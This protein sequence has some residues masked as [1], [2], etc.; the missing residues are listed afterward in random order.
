MAERKL[1]TIDVRPGAVM[2]SQSGL[3][4]LHPR[5]FGAFE[6]AEGRPCI[7][8]IVMH[9]ASNFMGHYLISPLARRGVSCMGLNSRYAGNDAV[10]IMERVTQDLGAGVRYLRDIGYEKVV[11]IGNSGGAAL[12]SFYQAQA[13]HL[14]ALTTP[15]GDPTGLSPGDLPPV[16]GVV[17]SAAHA[18]RSRLLK[19]WLDPSVVDESDGLG[20]DP[21]LD[22]YNPKNG[23]PYSEAFLAGYMEAQR[24]RKQRIDGWVGRRLRQLRSDGGPRRDEAF[25][26]HRT[27]A[28]PRFL[29]LS[30]DPNDREPGGI[31]AGG[32]ARA[33][34][35][36]ANSLGR[37]TSLTAYM[38]Q[39]S[40]AS[41]ADG[42]DNIARTSVPVL[43][44]EHTGDG[45]SFPSTTK[46]WTDAAKG[47]LTQ[48]ELKGGNHY[49]H[50][51]PELVELAAER[52]ADWAH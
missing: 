19:E 50:G 27:Y 38:S 20:A 47:R 33:V 37:Y 30:I 29:D 13:E 4:A 32:D 23:P 24:R 42:P 36:A 25:V 3:H 26:I 2:E 34:N 8:A 18:G 7:G 51:Q 5:I 21:D 1:V 44:L 9:P 12:A 16:D 11:L 28:D 17:L 46:L 41:Q 43:F 40:E 48:C 10:L 15:A 45:S 49:L 6:E 35:Y 22:M 52:I 14:T 31:W 39:W